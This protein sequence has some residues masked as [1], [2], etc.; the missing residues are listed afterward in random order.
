MMPFQ[1]LNQPAEKNEVPL[2]KQSKTLFE[3]SLMS[4]DIFSFPTLN[5]VI[6]LGSNQGKLLNTRELADRYQF[7]RDKS[8]TPLSSLTFPL[9]PQHFISSLLTD[10]RWGH[11]S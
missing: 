3:M 10:S 9:M 5:E 1:L 2:I 11:D 6:T 7:D 8:T 4:S